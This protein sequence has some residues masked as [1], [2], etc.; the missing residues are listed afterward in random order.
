L[1]LGS[2]SGRG[3]LLGPWTRRHADKAHAFL[4]ATP[5][6]LCDFPLAEPALAMPA[7][8]CFLLRPPRLRDEQGPRG[9]LL[10]PGGA[11]LAEGTGTRDSGASIA[12]VLEP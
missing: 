2:G 7:P 4:S 10:A 9:G 6:P 8:G 5:I 12:L 11:G 1:L 3:V